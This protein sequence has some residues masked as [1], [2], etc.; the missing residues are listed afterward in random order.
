MAFAVAF[1]R[2]G[3]EI[4]EAR[5]V[6]EIAGFEPGCAHFFKVLTIFVVEEL[7]TSESSPCRLR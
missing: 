7:L 5:R 3:S 4:P 1:W 6:D 2:F